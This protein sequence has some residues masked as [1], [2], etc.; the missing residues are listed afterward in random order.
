MHNQSYA[1][2]FWDLYVYQNIQ[3]RIVSCVVSSI[4]LLVS[5]VFRINNY[6][7]KLQMLT[8]EFINIF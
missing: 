3:N 2:W 4:Q 7:C 1:V 8:N 6:I 5:N